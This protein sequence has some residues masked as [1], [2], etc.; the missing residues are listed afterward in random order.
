MCE[1]YAGEWR[2]RRVGEERCMKADAGGRLE[3]E[4]GESGKLEVD[5]NGHSAFCALER[6]GARGRKGASRGGKY[7]TEEQ[8]RAE[9][10]AKISWFALVMRV[11]FGTVLLWALLFTDIG[12]WGARAVYGSV[13]GMKGKLTSILPVRGDEK[14]VYCPSRHLATT[15]LF[16]L[17]R[18]CRHSYT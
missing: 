17:P 9:K 4:R 6:S 1:K 15:A 10:S 2:R 7:A 3:K 18:G 11:V 14:Y 16:L 12:R 8:Q 5:V 13:S